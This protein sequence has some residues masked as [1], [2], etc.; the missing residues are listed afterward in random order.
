[1]VN[2][3][4]AIID[5]QGYTVTINSP[6]T[7]GSGNGGLTKAGSGTLDLATANT[8]TGATTVGAGTLVLGNSLALEDSTL[9]TSGGGTVN[10]GSFTAVTLGGLQ[11][12]NGL[13]LS[14]SAGTALAL[15]VGNNGQNTTFA[16]SLSGSGALTKIGSG[17]ADARRPRLFRGVDR[18]KRRDPRI[19]CR[20][21]HHDHRRDQLEQ[22]KRHASWSRRHALVFRR[23]CAWKRVGHGGNYQQTGGNMT[24]SNMT[25]FTLGQSVN[26]GSVNISGGTLNSSVGFPCRQQGPTVR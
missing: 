11:G 26:A 9:D 7:A 5:T 2:A 16:G 19:G 1:M 15:S 24:I 18:A 23:Q 13:S 10:F 4:G 25:W 22:F 3:G 20:I 21:G 14:N 17:N 8:F 6:L 12:P